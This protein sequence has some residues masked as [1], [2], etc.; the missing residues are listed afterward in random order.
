MRKEK[1]ILNFD[2]IPSVVLYIM[3][4]LVALTVITSFTFYILPTEKLELYKETVISIVQRTPE[5]KVEVNQS[6][7]TK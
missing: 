4:G 1:H 7:K 6:H 5:V 3:L 2:F